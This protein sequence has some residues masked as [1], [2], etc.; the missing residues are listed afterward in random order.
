[1]K[2][3]SR[4]E[5][6]IKRDGRPA[7]SWLERLQVIWDQHAHLAANGSRV[8]SSRTKRLRIE[9]LKRC[10]RD[11]RELGY[12]LDD[13]RGL[14]PKHIE[15]LVAH[16]ESK[17]LAAST[18]QN[19]VSVLRTFCSWIGKD[20]MVRDTASYASTPERVKVQT[21]AT[22]SKAW[23]DHGV[24]IN[25][26][27]AEIEAYDRH[28]GMQ[29]RMCLVFGL[30]RREAVM[31][32]PHRAD[33][34]NYLAVND[35]T[36]GG[37]D[38]VVS[39]DSVIKRETLDAAKELVGINPD[40]PLGKRGSTLEQALTRYT[41]VLYRC[42]VSHKQLEVTGHGLRHEYMNERYEELTGEKSPVRGGARPDKIVEERARLVIAE[43]AGH[44]R[45]S[46]TS[47]YYGTHYNLVRTQNRNEAAQQQT[48][49]LPSSE[50]PGS[51]DIPRITHESDEQ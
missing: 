39:I 23:S 10:F 8:L 20:G 16:W 42:G 21:S 43:E 32:K 26:K 40:A 18:I 47:A 48:G 4:Y 37:R 38:R 1:M 45:K 12:K 44:T 6:L 41:N 15:A 17:D 30:R 33:R 27:I 31:M 46:I 19:N 2:Q 22:E 24:D 25:A 51:S 5:P 7:Y 9:R 36:K 49:G 50:L 35:G 34:G 3:V 13:P 14:K 11:L 28:V 29:V